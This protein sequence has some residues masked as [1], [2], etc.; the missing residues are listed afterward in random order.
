[1]QLSDPITFSGRA[2][3]LLPRRPSPVLQK[4]SL[5]LRRSASLQM[6]AAPC[7]F[8]QRLTARNGEFE[9]DLPVRS[10]DINKL[11]WKTGFRRIMSFLLSM[12]SR[13]GWM[14]DVE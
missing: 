12:E 9:S 8:V 2:R 13:A 6:H 7:M 10:W 1:M 4:F 11:M 14:V 5:P 3:L